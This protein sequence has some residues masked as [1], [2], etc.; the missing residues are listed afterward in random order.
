L[1]QEL[2]SKENCKN[3]HVVKGACVTFVEALP[4]T[5]TMVTIVWGQVTNDN[6]TKV[7]GEFLVKNEALTPKRI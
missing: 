7:D 2:H 1:I 5:T 4:L 6:F 3:N